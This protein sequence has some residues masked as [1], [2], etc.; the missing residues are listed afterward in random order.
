M[1]VNKRRKV[2]NKHTLLESMY[3]YYKHMLSFISPLWGL[4]KPNHCENPFVFAYTPK[5]AKTSFFLILCF[6]EFQVKMRGGVGLK[7]AF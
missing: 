1:S 6:W 7:S 3:Y 4:T 5:I 2:K